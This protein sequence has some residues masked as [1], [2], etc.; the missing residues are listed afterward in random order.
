MVIIYGDT[1]TKDR[2]P[3]YLQLMAVMEIDEG[4]LLK[5]AHLKPG[6]SRVHWGVSHHFHA[7]LLEAI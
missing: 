7:N 2:T 1:R 3:P 4:A 6:V 5:T